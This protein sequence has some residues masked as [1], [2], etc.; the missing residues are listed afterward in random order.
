MKKI[1]LSFAIIA[2]LV[3]VLLLCPTALAE[4]Y[5]AG[6]IRLLH[7]EGEV[8]ILD[9]A[10]ETRFI[11]DNVRFDNGETLITGED[12]L[13]A[14]SL[15]TDRI[16]T[17]DHNSRVIFEKQSNAMK[18]TLQEG[19]LLLDV[20]NKLDPNETLDIRTSTMTVGI[21]GTIVYL[22]ERPGEEGERGVTTLGVLEGT[23]ELTYQNSFGAR[24]TVQVDRGRI[25]TVE[26]AP[27][28]AIT[29][30][31]VEV[32][33][34]EQIPDFVEELPETLP[35]TILRVEDA[36]EQLEEE[37]EADPDAADGDWRWEEPVTLVAQSAS[38][39]FDG[40]PLMRPSDALVYGLPARFT[41][42]VIAAG[43]QTDAGES[44][45]VIADYAIYNS[46]GE[47]VTDH[48]PNIETVSGKLVV[49][50][51]PLTIWTGSAWK[52]Y[53]GTPLTEASAG[54]TAYPGVERNTTPWRNL[55]YVQTTATDAET[56]YGVT[57]VTW[58]HGTNPL[59]GE[60]REIALQAGEKLTVVLSE[61]GTGQSIEY[62]VEPMTVEELPEVL[63]RL[64]ARNPALLA[65]A[66]DDA[67]WEEEEIRARIAKLEEEDATL[68]LRKG[69]SLPENEAESLLTDCTNVRITIDTDITSYNDRPLGSDEAH[70]TPVSIPEDIVVTATG[71]QTQVG[72]S[73]NTY[74]M[75]WGTSRPENYI[76]SEELGTLTV[77]TRND[78]VTVTADSGSKTYDG[79]PLTAGS[80]T[81]SGLPAGFT[82]TATVTGS[83]TDAGSSSAGISSYTIRDRYGA[84]VTA[85]F[86]NVTRVSGTLTVTP[87]PLTITTGSAS[88]VYDG[89]PLES[90]EVT[91]AVSGGAVDTG[92]VRSGDGASGAQLVGNDTAVIIATGSITDA[93]TAQNSYT[94]DWGSTKP[95]N[96]SVTENL[97]TLEV[98]ALPVRFS[99]GGHTAEYD[100]DV[101]LVEITSPDA[102]RIGQWTLID[103]AERDIGVVAVF[104]IPGGEVGLSCY[105]FAD[106]GTYTLSAE[107]EL[108]SG[109]AENYLFSCTD[110][111]MT[112]T[113]M[114]VTVRLHD[115]S[116][117]PYNGE[118]QLGNFSAS[119]ASFDIGYCYGGERGIVWG[120]DRFVVNV[121]GGGSAPGSYTLACT[122]TPEED[123]NPSNYNFT[124]TDTSLTIG[125]AEVVIQTPSASKPY[126]GTA[127]TASPATVTGLSS[128]DAARVTVT[129][130]GTITS[131]GTTQNTYTIDWGGADSSNYTVTEELGTLKVHKRHFHFTVYANTGSSSNQTVPYK[132][133]WYSLTYSW[134]ETD[135]DGKWINISYIYS[136]TSTVNTDKG[137]FRYP[138]GDEFVVSTTG[139]GITP[140]EYPT[141]GSVSFNSGDSS[142]YVFDFTL[143][144]LTITPAP[145]TITTGSA[146]KTYDGTPLT[147]SE[148]SITGLVGGQTATVTATGTQTEIGS[149]TNG[150]S[151][152]WGG[153]N[154][155][156]YTITEELGT[157][158]V[159]PITVTITTS[160]ETK[161]YDGTPLHGSFTVEG[162]PAGYNYAIA[163][164]TMTG[165]QT[166]VGSS[167]N[168][169][170][171]NG[172]MFVNSDLNPVDTSS[173][174]IVVKLGTLTVTPAG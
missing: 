85:L 168:T 89:T 71:S 165:S 170:D 122:F 57:G 131:A 22:T 154:P 74:T 93:G 50:P 114:E 6:T 84:D 4:S 12:G 83:Q 3:M 70:Y 113:P 158:T 133:S 46:R 161:P 127:L 75:S 109:K 49:D 65:Q 76:L 147:N 44:A 155:A 142:N 61:E 80:F 115:G 41:I 120:S 151:I 125:Q 2:L 69:L 17:L 30:T 63:L 26:S 48:F 66:C 123:A 87:A 100:G 77:T 10:G 9:A 60:T 11:M 107:T 33:T 104:M 111:E 15:D 29:A 64:Y 39:L 106:A 119:N 112:I 97:G 38:K 7:H 173:W 144:T 68:V 108:N 172:I 137:T 129:C 79:T 81:F 90:G 140:G 31:R 54:V 55:S 40:R 21:R 116:T 34:R 150:Y 56:L 67:G 146:S 148:A 19:T 88:K 152:A 124:V 132:G 43:A 130:T 162:L 51:A 98:T 37:A 16:V 59:T 23:A 134:R 145:L 45:N 99:L 110:T 58:V 42:R 101:Q 156:N 171:L 136:Y 1:R 25:A 47:D 105:G 28:G 149:S 24:Q 139:G 8:E 5:S 78:P 13:A 159:T 94:I 166:E 91:V 18:L 103:D 141:T 174:T 121:T 102:E 92:A 52:A 82:L 36:L 20:Q 118:V 126:D 27:D 95:S 157:L 160:T 164:G 73:D 86:T 96:Y 138:W 117:L 35:S 163:G 32:L 72:Q 167:E 53:D 143:T 14:I 128:A 169:I 62:K 135:D 153:A